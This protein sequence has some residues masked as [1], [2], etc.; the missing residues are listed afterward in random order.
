[1]ATHLQQ[2]GGDWTQ[3]KLEAVR[4]YLVAYTTALKKQPFTLNYIDAFAGTGYR[5]LK[6]EVEPGLFDLT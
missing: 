5:E 6:H 1:M 2:F 4:K 3:A